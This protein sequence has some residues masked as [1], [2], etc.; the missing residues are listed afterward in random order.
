M[1]DEANHQLADHRGAAVE[2]TR[3][4]VHDRVG[5][6]GAK[7]RRAA[8]EGSLGGFELVRLGPRLERRLLVVGSAH[9]GEPNRPHE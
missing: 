5:Q 3:V 6:A 4:G 8:G 7:Q 1:P 9:R 2:V